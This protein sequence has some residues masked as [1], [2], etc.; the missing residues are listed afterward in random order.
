[1]GK[2]RADPTAHPLI[3]ITDDLEEVNAYCR[4]YHHGE[5]PG[6]VTEPI[7]DTEL[8]GYVKRTL[9]LVGYLS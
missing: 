8:Q 5:N 7:D 2:I 9:R 3:G 1:M 4:R 6:A